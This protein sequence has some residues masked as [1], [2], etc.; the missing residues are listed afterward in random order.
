MKRIDLQGKTFG[1]LTVLALSERRDPSG[2]LMWR[3]QCSCGN[4]A[5]AS[6]NKLLSG[7][8]KSCGCGARAKPA[9]PKP[10]YMAKTD[11]VCYR[12]DR[13]GGCVALTEKLCVTRGQCKFY[14]SKFDRQT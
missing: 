3:C 2:A 4:I 7:K 13:T 1:K 12:P 10:E 11:C 6:A 8:K 9:P 5:Y 14:K